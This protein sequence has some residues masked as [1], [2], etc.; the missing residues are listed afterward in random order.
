M[1]GALGVTVDN[2]QAQPLPMMG[3]VG[4]ASAGLRNWVNL[5]QVLAGQD[6]YVAHV[7]LAVWIGRG[8]HVVSSFRRSQSMVWLTASC[9][10]PGWFA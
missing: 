1:A 4:I 6:V 8:G 10:S 3:N 2:V 7:P 5:T 9:R